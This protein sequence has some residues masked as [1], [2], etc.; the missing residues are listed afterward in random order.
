MLKK[1]FGN[2]LTLLAKLLIIYL[3]LGITVFPIITGAP[4]IGIATVLFGHEYSILP[5][6]Y[7]LLLAF[8]IYIPYLYLSNKFLSVKSNIILIYVYL[9]L[10]T[11]GLTIYMWMNTENGW[12]PLVLMMALMLYPNKYAFVS[13]LILLTYI[14]FNGK[15]DDKAKE[16]KC[17]SVKIFVAFTY[18]CLAAGVP[19]FLK[20]QNITILEKAPK[21]VEEPFN[22][23][24][25][26]NISKTKECVDDAILK[27]NNSISVKWDN[28]IYRLKNPHH[29]VRY[30]IYNKNFIEISAMFTD[31]FNSIKQC[32]AIDKCR[33]YSKYVPIEKG[34]R[35]D[36]YQNSQI[37]TDGF[38]NY[39]FFAAYDNKKMMN[40]YIPDS[41]DRYV[42]GRNYEGN[43]KQYIESKALPKKDVIL[44]KTNKTD[45]FWV[46]GLEYI[47]LID[48][49]YFIIFSIPRYIEKGKNKYGEYLFEYTKGYK[50]Y[51]SC[52]GKKCYEQDLEISLDSRDDPSNIYIHFGNKVY[53]INI[54]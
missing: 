11:I 23:P 18:L 19:Y 17:Q 46:V 7:S 9:I 25:E 36:V 41:D 21:Q 42:D 34:L 32:Y 3:F 40:I 12:Q 16:N 50:F 38:G 51:T 20:W 35:Y 24:V 47:P 26:E 29:K 53:K 13:N 33:F 48:D 30:S 39:K 27:K 4:L 31:K 28:L 10:Y 2:R 52:K 8:C 6:I 14:I 1:L 54:P 5:F 22:C 43:I 37:R 15:N 44:S 49:N 45:E